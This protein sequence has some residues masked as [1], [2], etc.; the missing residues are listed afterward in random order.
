[1]RS[2]SID[3]AVAAA[4]ALLAVLVYR[5]VLGLWWMYDDAFILNILRRAQLGDVWHDRAIYARFGLPI[6]NPLLLASLK[7]DLL[8]FGL[9][10]RA[11]YVHQLVAFAL[12]PPL[13][14]LLLRLWSPPLGAAAA[15]A[16]FTISGPTLQ[17]VPQLMLRHYIEGAVLAIAAVIAFVLALWRRSWRLALLSAVFYFGAMAAKEVYAPLLLLLLVMPETTLRE[18]LRLATPHLAAALTFA[19]WRGLMVGWSLGAY[20]FLAPPG[21][22]ALTIASLPLRIARE[23]AGFGSAAGWTLFAMIVACAAI[24]V[25]RRRGARLPALAVIVAVVAPLVPV[26]AEMNPRW[27]FVA[28]LLA[29]IPIAFL[30]RAA[31][32]VLAVAIITFRVEW[33]P[34]YR[35]FVRM[36]DEARVFAMLGAGDVLRNPATPPVSLQELGRMTGSPARFVNDDLPLCNG[37]APFRRVFEYD[38]ASRQVRETTRANLQRS[39]AAIRRMPLSLSLHFEPSGAFYWTAGPYRDGQWAFILWERWVYDVPAVGGFRSPQIQRFDLRVRYT[40]PAGWRTYSPMLHVDP[41]NGP[42]SF[43]Q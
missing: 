35:L 31:V 43:R 8:R 39:C 12:L 21:K 5:K 1:M 9:D 27:A 38:G 3:A 32:V 34:A 16:V 17:V 20:G 41:R 6:F 37:T 24:V 42:L 13:L 14:Y 40:S 4:L 10:A 7:A 2:K 30:P 18:R 23:L 19:I 28:G 11:F 22:R 33:G 29:V 36:S 25:V 15:A 26:A